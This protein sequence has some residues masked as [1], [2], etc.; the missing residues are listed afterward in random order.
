[1][2]T[3]FDEG[4][5]SGAGGWGVTGGADAGPALLRALRRRAGLSQERLAEIASVHVRTVRGLETGRIARPRRTTIELLAQALGLDVGGQLGL[6]AA[7][8]LHEAAR[9]AR[10]APPSST[11]AIDVIEA[12]LTEGSNS[13]RTV[14]L[15]E[16]VVIGADHRIQRRATSEVAVALVDGV[17]TR[18]VFY[19]PDDESIDIDRFHVGELIN[20]SVVK[21]LRDPG[22]RGKLFELALERTLS[23][24]QTQVLHYSVDFAAARRRDAAAAPSSHDE[25]AGFLRSPASYVLEIRFDEH[26]LPQRCWQVFQP[27]PTGPIQAVGDLQLASTN[28]VHIA[29]LDPKAGGHG[30]SWSW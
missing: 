7:W 24:G 27:R 30:I 26:A 16:V 10:P 5:H 21:E 1:V 22:G 2:P 29:L 12:F 19:D 15:S 14:A 4:T 23:V 9:P 17:R 3:G 18:C 25:I 13:L 6:L 8:G 11:T 28:S 20:C